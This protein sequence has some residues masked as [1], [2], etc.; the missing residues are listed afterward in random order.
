MRSEPDILVTILID[1]L[2]GSPGN[3]V[4]IKLLDVLIGKAV[5]LSLV[6]PLEVDCVESFTKGSDPQ[7]FV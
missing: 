1:R 3:I 6:K 4:S 2:D 5:D 7:R